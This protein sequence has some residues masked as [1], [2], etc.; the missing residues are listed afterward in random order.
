MAEEWVGG[1]QASNM[2]VSAFLFRGHPNQHYLY[3]A[4]AD[5]IRIAGDAGR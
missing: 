1:A 3:S 5:V 4:A 2:Y